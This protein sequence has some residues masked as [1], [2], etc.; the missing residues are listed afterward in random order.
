MDLSL[1]IM[2]STDPPSRLALD[3]IGFVTSFKNRSVSSSLITDIADLEYEAHEK[4]S[5]MANTR[6]LINVL[7]QKKS[8]KEKYFANI[9]KVTEQGLYTIIT[10]WWQH[11]KEEKGYSQHT[12]SSYLSD[13]CCFFSFLGSHFNTVI[14]KKSLENCRLS[15]FRSY[16][17]F[18]S[19]KQGAASRSR[20]LSAVRSLYKYCEKNDY[21]K[22]EDIFLLK[23]PKKPKK[24]PRAIDINAALKSTKIISSLEEQKK[25]PEQW[26]GLRDE[27]LLFVIYGSGLRISEAINLKVKDINESGYIKVRGKGSKER[28]VPIMSPVMEKLNLLMRQCPFCDP[29]YEDSY[30]F[31]GKQGKHMSPRIFQRVI[32]NLRNSLGLP[33]NTTPH[34][35]RHSFATHLLTNSDGDL[36]SIQELLGHESLS[37]TQIYTKVDPANLLK[38]YNSVD[39]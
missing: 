9:Q 14:S 18:L 22:N 30:I 8:P 17:S 38:S 12:L 19:G 21:F 4:N 2:I 10:E 27:T 23:T 15:D 16:M 37:S 13:I 28:L 3:S 33:E 20:S 6:I 34:A 11:L 35:F 29:S 39:N 1:T 5:I 25:N 7:M 32:E 31:F 24:L 36:R 26:V